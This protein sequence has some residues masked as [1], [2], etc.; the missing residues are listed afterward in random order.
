L[1]GHKEALSYQLSASSQYFSDYPAE[2]YDSKRINAVADDLAE[3]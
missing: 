1:V 3:S 2:E